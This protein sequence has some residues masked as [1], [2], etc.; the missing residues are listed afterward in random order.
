MSGQALIRQPRLRSRDRTGEASIDP[1]MPDTM[2][3]ADCI[4]QHA[5][6]YGTTEVSG[7]ASTVVGN[8]Y[9]IYHY[10]SVPTSN[11]S[12]PSIN[13][14]PI[15]QQSLPFNTSISQLADTSR[16]IRV[17]DLHDSEEPSRSTER[18]SECSRPQAG[19]VYGLFSSYQS[20]DIGW[21]VLLLP[22]IPLFAW[23]VSLLYR[24][25]AWR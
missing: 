16:R 4:Y 6:R 13:A 10:H 22:A 8:V 24:R 18:D 5:H 1:Y 12:L 9:H 19:L 3:M 2:E 14:S 15:S 17:P 7:Q 20:C 25:Y 23:S 21:T 11:A